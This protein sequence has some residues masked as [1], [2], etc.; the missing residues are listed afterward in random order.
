MAGSDEKNA[1]MYL[2]AGFG[3]GALLG[4]VAG[5]LF[6]PKSGSETRKELGGKLDESKHQ[7]SEWI[8]EQRAKRAAAAQTDEASEEAGA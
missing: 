8:K 6:A 4:A 2:L 3:L 7:V 5:I 1:L